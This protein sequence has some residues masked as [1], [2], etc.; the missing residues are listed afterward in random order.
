MG[1]AGLIAKLALSAG[2]AASADAP[3]PMPEAAVPDLAAAQSPPE[4]E[5]AAEPSSTPAPS[6]EPSPADEFSEDLKRRKLGYLTV[7]SSDPRA[8]V[9]VNLK[10]RGKIDEKLT[11]PC[12]DRFVSVGVPLPPTGVPMWLAPG[13]S[14]LVPCGGPLEITMD[15]QTLRNP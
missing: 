13:K 2:P 10:R 15:P 1:L 12:G 9:Y 11:V 3:S 4:P 6:A 14:M 7:H 5:P 8:Y